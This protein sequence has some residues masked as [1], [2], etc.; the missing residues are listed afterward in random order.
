MASASK[1]GVI[2]V[3]FQADFTTY[4]NGSLAVPDSGEDFIRK[5]Q[6]AT[7][8][9]NRSG[10]PI[11]AT[12][13]WHPRNHISFYTSHPGAKLFKTITLTD[14]RTQVMWPPHCVQ[15]TPGADVLIDS[16]LTNYQIQS[17]TDPN[18]EGYSGFRDDG[19]RDTGLESLLKKDGIT[20]VVIYGIAT[21]YCVKATALDAIKAGY[22][23]VLVKDLCRGVAPDTSQAALAEMAAAGIGFMEAF[24]LNKVKQLQ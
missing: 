18:Y 24:D 6:S 1:I 22:R 4:K 8:A 13:D 9:L 16:A 23:V 3:D 2:V 12:L 20:T 10:F 14:G 15:G 5:V 19:G 17:A 7:Q 11:Y 21:D